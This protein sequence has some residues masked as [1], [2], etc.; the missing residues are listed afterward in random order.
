MFKNDFDLEIKR[1]VAVVTL[2]PLDPRVIVIIHVSM[3]FIVFRDYALPTRRSEPTQNLLFGH[4][5][6]TL[7]QYYFRLEAILATP[8][9]ESRTNTRQTR[10]WESVQRTSDPTVQ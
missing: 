1:I 6:T 2:D 7:P 3:A 9:H 4:A 5:W 8:T 10:K